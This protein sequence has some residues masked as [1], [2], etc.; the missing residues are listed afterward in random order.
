MSTQRHVHQFNS[1]D[2]ATSL[3][4]EEEHRPRGLLWKNE[5]TADQARSQLQKQIRFLQKH[6]D[7]NKVAQLLSDKLENC[8]R[9]HRCISGA[10][11][12]CGWLFQRSWVRKSKLIID[13]MREHAPDLIAIT[14]VPPRDCVPAGQLSTLSIIN[15]KRRVKSLL[16]K[17][18]IDFAL[19]GIDFSFD[20]DRDDGYSSFWC[21]HAY[22]IASTDDRRELK[23][24]LNRFK[25]IIA[26]PRPTQIKSFENTPYRRSYAMKMHFRR[27]I[28]YPDC[29]R[30]TSHDRL[31]ATELLEL[32]LYL[33]EIGFSSRTILK[34]IKRSVKCDRGYFRIRASLQTA[35]R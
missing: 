17:A 2:W 30:N 15:M 5:W 34:G 35:E 18:D 32:S 9:R 27:R 10:C 3:I 28:G 8:S 7:S 21:P 13:R 1:P 4:V 19:G 25:P 33:D 29:R 26:I 22:I 31:R 11:P 20:E 14:I 16:D 24:C 6:G 12:V 23:K